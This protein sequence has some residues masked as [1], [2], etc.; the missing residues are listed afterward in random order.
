MGTTTIGVDLGVTSA[1]DVA[2]A[3]GTKVTAT[4]KVAS[5]PEALTAIG[6]GRA[7]QRGGGVHRDGV[8]RGG[9]RGAALGDRRHGVSGVGDQ[10][11]GAAQVLS[12]PH[13]DRPD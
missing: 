13:Q 3:E 10:G 8:V 5:T 12:G 2:V 11:G 7:G 4:R 1:S 9:G 6:G